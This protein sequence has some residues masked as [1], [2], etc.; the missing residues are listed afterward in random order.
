LKAQRSIIAEWS[1]SRTRLLVEGA[2]HKFLVIV[3]TN[4]SLGEAM[5]RV[6]KAHAF[7]FG[8]DVEFERLTHEGYALPNEYIVGEV[9]EDR[10][11]VT[12]IPKTHVEA[13]SKHCKQTEPE[14]TQELP[15]QAA[16]QTPVSPVVEPPQP[17]T[18]EIHFEAPIAKDSVREAREVQSKPLLKVAHRP[19]EQ[20]RPGLKEVFRREVSED[21]ESDSE[22]LPI[23]HTPKRNLFRT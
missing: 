13:P 9:L 10:A 1:S 15:L 4:H 7:C 3:R 14:L 6:Q 21:S 22:E 16:L 11:K 5:R 18:K 20:A 2:G 8:D 23:S 19:K 12:A 17:K